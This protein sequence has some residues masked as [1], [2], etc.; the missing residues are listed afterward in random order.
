[1]VQ[2]TSR[3]AV[4]RKTGIRDLPEELL[5]EIISHVLA[6]AKPITLREPQERR[7]AKELADLRSESPGL[8]RRKRSAPGKRRPAMRKS[9]LIKVLLV[10]K[11][12]YF[13]GLTSYYGKN[14]FRFDDVAHLEL[15]KA[16]FTIRHKACIRRIQLD[17]DWIDTSPASKPTSIKD[18]N[19]CE[20]RPLGEDPFVDFPKLDMVCINCTHTGG[21]WYKLTSGSGAR[22]AKA[23]IEPKVKAAWPSRSEAFV[24]KYP[25]DWGIFP[26]R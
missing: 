5:E 4:E 22:L 2:S 9:P 10:C 6:S 12:F 15:C 21:G 20:S 24:F 1:M 13:A 18:L 23:H 14:T 19:L 11:A 25:Q 8:S 7:W 3:S 16:R 26:H 17:L